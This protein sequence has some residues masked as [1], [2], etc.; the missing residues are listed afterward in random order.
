M[1]DPQVKQAVIDRFQDEAISVR[2][3]TVDL[4]GKYVLQQPALFD[5]YYQ[6]LLER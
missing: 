3:A 4:V 2:Q 6:P 5:A 1:M